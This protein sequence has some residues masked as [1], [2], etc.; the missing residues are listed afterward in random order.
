MRPVAFVFDLGNVVVRFDPE[1]ARL[2]IS[3]RSRRTEI[4]PKWLNLKIRYE[5]GQLDSIE[6]AESAI[7]LLEFEG[8]ATEFLE[9]WD[10]IFLSNSPMEQLVAQIDLPLYL[11]SNTSISHLTRIRRD[12][13]ILKRFINGV[14]SFEVGLLKPNPAIFQLT[15]ERFN[16]VGQRVIYIDDLAPNV[17][18]A[19][20]CGFEAY[21]YD[22][23]RH[24]EF[25][26]SVPWLDGKKTR[27]IAEM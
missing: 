14:Y 26:A 15:L 8:T 18:A 13:P 1:R 24:E 7:E 23:R 20:A 9:Y 11:L 6:F 25:V 2:P 3:A 5:T 4:E 16:L 17:A 21:Q 27:V 12:F 22:F 10:G 19:A